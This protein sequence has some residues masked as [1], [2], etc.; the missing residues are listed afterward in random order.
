MSVEVVDE[1][2]PAGDPL[3]LREKLDGLLPVKV[4]EEQGCVDNVDGVVRI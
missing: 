1:K 4:V 3:Q 2:A